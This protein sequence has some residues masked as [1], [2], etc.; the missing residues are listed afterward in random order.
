MDDDDG[1]IDC[2]QLWPEDAFEKAWIAVRLWAAVDKLEPK[3]RKIIRLRYRDG[4]SL[5]TIAKR[6]GISQSLVEKR[7]AR[8]LA[9]LRQYLGRRLNGS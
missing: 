4:R 7:L 1:G 2:V 3:D 6:L 8:T 5:K 9:E